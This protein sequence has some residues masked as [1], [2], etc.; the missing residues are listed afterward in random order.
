MIKLAAL[1][2]GLAPS[3]F[4][5]GALPAPAPAKVAPEPARL[6]FGIND[7]GGQLRVHLNPNWAVE[8]R[9]QTG[10]ASSNEGQIHSLVLGLRGYRFLQEH[11]R[12]RLYLGLEG[13]YAQTSIQGMP[14]TPVPPTGQGV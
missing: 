5:G 9:F 1:L 2:L 11:H 10:S 4:A 3:A 13:A 6:A 12:C 7:L 14:K 8:G